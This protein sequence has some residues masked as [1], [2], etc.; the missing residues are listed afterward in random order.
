MNG[1]K[2]KDTLVGAIVG[3]IFR[4]IGTDLA[5]MDQPLA[6]ESTM[7]GVYLLFEEPR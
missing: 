3:E 6:E 5:E 4:T 1:Q 2:H 7:Q